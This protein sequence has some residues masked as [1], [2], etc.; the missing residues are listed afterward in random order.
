[1][2][3]I[4][5]ALLR[6]HMNKTWLVAL[7]LGY[8]LLGPHNRFYR[9]ND[10]WIYQGKAAFS[11]IGV[12]VL[13]LLAAW[14]VLAARRGDARHLLLHRYH[15]LDAFLLLLLFSTAMNPL[16]IF[17]LTYLVT[18]LLGILF[19]EWLTTMKLS[20]GQLVGAISAWLGIAAIIAVTNLLHRLL[21]WTWAFTKPV[22]SF[23]PVNGQERMSLWFASPNDLG[24]VMAATI[25]MAIW[26]AEH[27]TARWQ[28]AAVILLACGL[29]FV[30]LET[31]SR[32]ALVA[33]CVGVLSYLAA[34]RKQHAIHL[35]VSAGMALI[36][37]G[38]LA[39]V[40]RYRARVASISDLR[41]DR[42]INARFRVWQE[43]MQIIRASPIVGVGLGNFAS[44]Y[45]VLTEGQNRPGHTTAVNN[46]LTLCA[47]TG[48]LTTICYLLILVL[49]VTAAFR[50]QHGMPHGLQRLNSALAA[51]VIVFAVY[52]VF[53]YNFAKTYHSLCWAIIGLICCLQVRHGPST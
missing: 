18:V 44:A 8:T 20:P 7:A 30:L 1:M 34:V 2:R 43:G 3:I 33:C 47:E 17:S 35:V 36:I 48:L 37:I 6:I 29:G 12:M 15:I 14:C 50:G 53:S 49:T 28:R 21:G 10:N 41:G 11:M 22:Q 16:T 45:A 40:G 38:I 31:Y 23:L 51:A 26:L 32:G 13:L 19:C 24:C 42:T 52:G 39:G 27:V 9:A 4:T 5:Q 46:Y 25:M